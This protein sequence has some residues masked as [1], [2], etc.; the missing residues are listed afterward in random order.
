MGKLARLVNNDFNL[1]NLH[2]NTEEIMREMKG[3][4][5]WK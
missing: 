4:G 5:T 1:I 3:P 2:A